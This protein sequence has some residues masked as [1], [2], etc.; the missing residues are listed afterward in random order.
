MDTLKNGLD[1][2]IYVRDIIKDKYM[3][4]GE[5]TLFKEIIFIYVMNIFK[6]YFNIILKYA[7]EYKPPKHNT[8]FTNEYYLSNILNVLSDIVTWKSTKQS[9]V[10]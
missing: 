1:Y 2:E 7:N 3:G 10:D 6:N 8:K 9:F 5:S 4:A